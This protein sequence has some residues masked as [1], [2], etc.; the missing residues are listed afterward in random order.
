MTS[1]TQIIDSV[2]GTPFRR[3]CLGRLN[4]LLKHSQI[5]GPVTYA[6]LWRSWVALAGLCTLS[7]IA[8]R[9]TV[10]EQG[11][12]YTF[13]SIVG[14]RVFFELGLGTVLTQYVSHERAGLAWATGMLVGDRKA[15]ERLGSL[16]RACFRWYAAAGALML[17]VVLP[18]GIFFFRHYSPAGSE[19]RW[20]FPWVGVIIG[21]TGCLL[22]TPLFALLEGCGCVGDVARMRLIDSL[23]SIVV[24]WLALSAGLGLLAAALF[25]LTSFA[26][27]LILL[28]SGHRGFMADLFRARGPSRFSWA[29]DLWPLQWRI[30]VSWASG[31][32]VF[33]L[34]SP[35]LFA[36]YGPTPA[37]QMGLSISTLQG[38]I[39]ISIAWVNTK[40]P[41]FGALIAQKRFDELDG[42]FTGATRRSLLVAGAAC[43]AFLMATIGLQVAHNPLGARVLAP[44]PLLF[45]IGTSLINVMV[46][47]RAMYLRAHKQEPF[48]VLSVF[49]GIANVFLVFIFGRYYGAAGMVIATFGVT[50]LIGWWSSRI[51]NERRRRWHSL[52]ERISIVEPAVL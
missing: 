9:L 25:S 5:D 24:L 8:R 2:R 15:K 47:A 52:P 51:F 23:V 33:Q 36:Y 34:Y 42:L 49:N 28:W 44:L 19:V 38:I 43:V 30:A 10:S 32:F 40:A 13:A 12:Y 21:S 11:F 14:S 50:S 39:A 7:L 45:L 29:R 18:G 31:Y 26:N 20:L 1:Q 3:A 27:Q 46:Y 37:G 22:L 17:I 4:E 6:L 41:L 16:L 35:V 48:L